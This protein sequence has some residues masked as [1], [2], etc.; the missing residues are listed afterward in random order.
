VADATNDPALRSWLNIDESSDF[1]IQNLPFGMF[2]TSGDP[3]P[4]AGVAIGSH[5]VDLLAVHR[6]GV[7]AFPDEEVLR[8]SLNG[9]FEFGIGPVRQRVSELLTAGNNELAA[10]RN[11]G[12]VAMGA[13]TMAMP[14]TIGDYVDFYSSEQHATNVGRM[15]RPD[16]PPLLP[17]WKHIPIAYH[18]R[19]STVV[20]SGTPIRRPRGQRPGADGPTFGPSQRLDIELE[21]GFFTSRGTELGVTIPIDEANNHIGGV[22]LVND[23]SARDIQAWEYRPLGP[24]LGK[25]FATSISPWVVTLE[26]LAPFWVTAPTQDP[27]PLPYLAAESNRSLDLTL[28]VEL[29]GA[30]IC[31]TGFRDMYWTMAQQLAHAASNGT[32]IR[33]GDLYASGTV[34]GPQPDEYGSLLELSWNG[35][36]PLEV[37]GEPRTFLEDGDTVRITGWCQH[38]HGPRIGFGEC[39][40]TILPAYETE[41]TT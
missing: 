34:S 26:A 18:G 37:A 30:P 40:G 14:F 3:L 32:A 7:M 35:E 6:S 9:L 22:V 5:I 38:G 29:N 20:I 21:V 11:R 13:A 16:D 33:P 12:I 24:Y 8:G 25:S 31:R 1:P 27:P 17:N 4:R 2:T 10:A 23:W 36:R 19:A 15:F 41:A 28:Q 39:V